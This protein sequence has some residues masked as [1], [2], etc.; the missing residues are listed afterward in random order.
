MWDLSRSG[1]KPVSP[2][3]AGG[4]FATEPPKKRPPPQPRCIIIVQGKKKKKSLRKPRRKDCQAWIRAG[5]CHLTNQSSSQQEDGEVSLPKRQ[6]NAV[7]ANLVL[8]RNFQT[9]SSQCKNLIVEVQLSSSV[10]SNSLQPHR[11]QPSRLPCPSS[12]PRVC[13]NMSTELVMPSN[14]LILCHLL[15]L[16]S[17]FSGSTLDFP[18]LCL[19]LI[20]VSGLDSTNYKAF[21]ICFL[22]KTVFN[23]K[24]FV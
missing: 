15:L 2:A 12:T 13:S 19:F 16:P 3:M 5:N 22:F 1:V 18:L 21:Q 6:E 24:I 4:F 9:F 7:I 8:K 17:N 23:K 10:M 20:P 14:H 11:L